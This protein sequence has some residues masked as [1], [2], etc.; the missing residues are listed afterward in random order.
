MSR[1]ELETARLLGEIMRLV[2]AA[3]RLEQDRRS[4][5]PAADGRE[6]DAL[7]LRLAGVVSRNTAFSDR[8][9]A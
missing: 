3:G 9:A 1:A 6:L 4:P 2:G 5:Q 8:A 7:R